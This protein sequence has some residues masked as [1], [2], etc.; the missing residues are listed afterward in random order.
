MQRG[1]RSFSS[2][3][4][5]PGIRPGTGPDGHECRAAEVGRSAQAID[6]NH[7]GDTA[8]RN[9]HVAIF[10]AGVASFLA[11][12]LFVGQG[13]GDTLWR[14]GVAATLVVLTASLLSPG[15]PPE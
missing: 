2:S 7:K 12:L 1:E 11:S 9:L 6:L 4:T 3:R 14:A 10:I 13:M 5:D 8:M 15:K